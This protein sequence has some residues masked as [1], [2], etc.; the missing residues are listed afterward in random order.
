MLGK[1]GGKGTPKLGFEPGRLENGGIN[2]NT[3]I[4]R[5]AD[6]DCL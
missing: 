6:Q 4:R 3:E 1:G 2:G 5:E